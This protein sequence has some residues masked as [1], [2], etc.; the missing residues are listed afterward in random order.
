MKEDFIHFVWR[1]KRF[2]LKALKTTEGAPIQILK[3]GNANHHAGPDFINAKIQ[4]GETLWVGNVEIH[5]KAS[6]WLKHNHQKDKAYN[7]V[8]LHV[9]LEEDRPIFREGNERIPCLELKRRIPA[10]ISKSY[11]KLIHN[12]HWIPCQHHIHQVSELNR[13]LWLDRLL[14]ERLEQKTKVIEQRLKEHKGNWEHTFYQFLARAFG[15]KI[16]SD[17]FDSL[18]NS[19]SYLL[20]AKYKD[21]LF[22]IEAL[23]FGQ[24]GILEK[25]FKDDYPNQLKK[26][27]QFLRKKHSLIPISETSWKFLR[28]RPSNFPTI[29]LAQFA[30]LIYQSVHLFRKLLEIENVAEIEKLLEVQLSGYW[31]T[32]YIFDRASKKRQKTLG[33]NA[34][35]LIIINTIVP[36]MFLYGKR[37]SEESFK[38]KA[39]KFLD[40]MPKEKNSIISKWEALGVELDSAYKSQALLQLKNEYCNKTQCLNCGIGNAIL[41]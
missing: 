9:V 38:E 5:L 7:N 6:E 31:L 4:I 39:L 25:E 18:A 11:L 36:F 15:F 29:R 22:Q 40:E 35:Q 27:Y 28:L 8:I 37:K 32:H 20:L 12:E 17:P 2:D 33:R 21:S 10:K 14:V 34:I 3:F 19:L 24:A 30:S 23:L 26:E 16:N 13:N 1:H 41:K